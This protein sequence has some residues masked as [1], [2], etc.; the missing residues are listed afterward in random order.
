MKK[1]IIALVLLLSIS[2]RAQNFEKSNI[3]LSNNE[4]STLIRSNGEFYEINTTNM[5]SKIAKYDV[6][7]N[8]LY[9]G[10]FDFVCVSE[11]FDKNA[12]LI[13]FNGENIIVL[14]VD[15]NSNKLNWY[16]LQDNGTSFIGLK[17][18]ELNTSTF[19][20]FEWGLWY[21]IKAL[22]NGEFLISGAVVD[23][24]IDGEM[25]YH[26]LLK[27]NSTGDFLWSKFYGLEFGYV[28]Y[29]MDVSNPSG[30]FEIEEYLNSN[31]EVNFLVA[32]SVTNYPN[33]FGHRNGFVMNLDENG[34][35][36]WLKFFDTNMSNCTETVTDIVKSDNLFK[37]FYNA[38]CSNS[39][40]HYF[41]VDEYGN[42]NTQKELILDADSYKSTGAVIYNN[43]L[44]V[45]SDAHFGSYYNAVISRIDL[46]IPGY[47]ESFKFTNSEYA[48]P[49]IE[50]NANGE[51]LISF[52]NVSGDNTI[53]KTI[54]NDFLKN[55]CV[56]PINSSLNSIEFLDQPVEFYDGG[57]IFSEVN[58]QNGFSAGI[59][60]QQY[61]NCLCPPFL[62][63]LGGEIEVCEGSPNI[64]LNPGGAV[65]YSWTYNGGPLPNFPSNPNA[66]TISIPTDPAFSG[67]YCVEAIDANGCTDIECVEIIINAGPNVVA[68][69]PN[70][71]VCC[72]DGIV[73]LGAEYIPTG[74]VYWTNNYFSPTDG[75][76]AQGQQHQP[77]GG[78]F[79]Q[80]PSCVY[81]TSGPWTPNIKSYKLDPC[82]CGPGTY[83]V[84]Y[85]YLD[86][87]TGCSNSAQMTIEVCVPPKKGPQSSSSQNDVRSISLQSN[88]TIYP[89]PTNDQI[90]I[91]LP[92]SESDIQLNIYSTTG[93]LVYS[94]TTNNAIERIDL[95]AVPAGVYI[96]MANGDFG[97]ITKKV[98]K[99]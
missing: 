12:N 11:K 60:I 15:Q 16:V 39:Q 98:T 34:Q 6:N 7:G 48:R 52:S 14:G 47:V 5:V 50:V 72:G 73:N 79:T 40:I 61:D 86:I 43:S 70:L 84:E 29:T 63:D 69:Q 8:F 82:A 24:T 18:R 37:I 75:W 83:V 4:G 45:V 55:Q 78:Q 28:G 66:Q 10:Q 3:T 54:F 59:S 25:P 90:T 97:T 27:L 57:L 71:T 13:G 31:N 53:S 96:V 26:F 91:E 94:Q 92:D 56:E 99:N 68:N 42:I 30:M 87:E 41:N 21:D 65:S 38:A 44:Y 17:K 89:N 49:E 62:S 93:Q 1:I 2:V 58:L 74:N 80:L 85:S 77:I 32:G 64:V 22:S 35:V 88:L 76:P 46:N 9:G 19:G 81:T 51:L 23:N 20:T 33:Q 36:I 67:T 95:S